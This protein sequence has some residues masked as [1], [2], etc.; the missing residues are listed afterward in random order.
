MTGPEQ[1]TRIHEVGTV[2]VPVSDQERALDFYTGTLGFEKRADFTSGG[3]LRWIE[4]APRGAGNSI[5]LVPAGEDTASRGDAAYCAFA[6]ADIEADLAS[7]RARG[8]EVDAE[9][10]RAGTPRAGLISL[11]ATVP[12]R[13]PR[14]SSSAIPTATAS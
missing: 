2:F 7:L 8:V 6:T 4:V 14:S 10:A 1:A 13:C 11:A 9:I 3:G 5:S 12:V